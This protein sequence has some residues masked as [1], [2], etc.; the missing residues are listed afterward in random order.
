LFIK[1]AFPLWLRLGNSIN[2]STHKSKDKMKVAFIVSEAFPFAKTG[3]LADVAG[4]LPKALSKLGCD[5]KIFMP[6]YGLIDEHKYQLRFVES[7]NIQ[8]RIAGNIRNTFLHKGFLPGTNVEA[9]FIDCPHYFNRGKIYT[10]NSDEDERFILFNKAVLEI[11]LKSGWIP[12]IVH[13]NDW[14]TGLLPHYIKSDYNQDSKLY[15]TKTLFTIH[16]VGYQGVFRNDTFYKSEINRDLVNKFD[17]DPVDNFSFLKIGILFSDIINT[18]SPTYATEIIS[19]EYGSGMERILK[20]KRNKLYGIINGIDYS[21]W[22]TLTDENIPFHF[23]LKNLNFK[24][25]NKKYLLEKFN[26]KFNNDVPLIGVVSRMVKQKGFDLVEKVSKELFNL[27]AQWIILGRGENQYEDL[28]RSLAYTYPDK[29]ANYI[30]Y[31]NQLAH[32]I[33]AGSDMFLMPSHYEPCGLNQLYS[34]RYGTVPIVRKTGGLADTVQDWHELKISGSEKGTGFSFNSY[35]ASALLTTV[36]RA[37]DAF[38]NKGDW[39]KI[40]ING[41]RD[42]F[43]WERSG[44]EYIKL[45]KLAMSKRN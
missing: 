33:E 14:Q 20:S 41:I 15:K 21:E 10:D 25:R 22:N 16:N 2:A 17:P 40:Q 44:K 11:I 32:L 36:R 18:V 6:K 28:F 8:I 35:S 29:V 34:L 24:N 4:A 23:S 38:Y 3:G 27:N 31:D 19:P 26:L 37:I 5:I 42:D 13:C 45:Y 43:S 39:K 1:D 9:N 30:G 12:D 7:I